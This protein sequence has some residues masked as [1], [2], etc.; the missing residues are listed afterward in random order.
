MFMFSF[1]M[2]KVP[3]CYTQDFLAREAGPSLPGST[4]IHV[5][6]SVQRFGLPWPEPGRR[7]RV[8]GVATCRTAH[9]TL[10]TGGSF[11]PPRTSAPS[12]TL[13]QS[14]QDEDG[15][16]FVQWLIVVAAL[17]A[18]DAGGTAGLARALTDGLQRRLP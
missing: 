18:L 3:S 14:A 10:I 16:F 6:E 1:D 9:L 13:Q 15:C 5:S 7:L 11:A 12:A 4:T 8:L 17:G 2:K